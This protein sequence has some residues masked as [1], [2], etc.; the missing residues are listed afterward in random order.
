MPAAV[1]V[2][3]IA[4]ALV[5][6]AAIGIILWRAV[7]ARRLQ[8]HICLFP[9]LPAGQLLMLYSFSLGTWSV[10]WLLG[11]LLG[12][13]A[14]VLLLAYTIS[15]EKKAAAQESLREARHRR[16]LEKSHYEAVERRREEL[17]MICKAFSGELEAIAGFAQ[18]GN[19]EEAREGISALAERISH[20]KDSPYCAIPVINAILTEKQ[21]NCAA[22]GIDLAVDL[23][24][25]DALAVEPM[26]LC[27]IFSNLLDNAI[28][29]CMKAQGAGKPVI[30]LSALTD[31]DYL[32]IKAA[33]PSAEPDKPAPGR[34]YGTRIL[35]E[36]A[37]Q[38]DGD[39][40]SGYRDGM[41]TA[42]VSLL[43][44]ER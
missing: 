7:S 21:Q 11:L 20:T 31:G 34:G 37:K 14:N 12:F 27:S 26:H 8:A 36:L 22:A 35:K 1:L 33:N 10:F 38:Y 16:D 2:L 28:A 17:D 6:A 24:L 40:Q 9:I 18:S 39:F 43:A 5:L 25:P 41:F 3:N 15:H 32:F 29:A 4:H 42:V 23:Y 44:A 30:R 13:A 19:G